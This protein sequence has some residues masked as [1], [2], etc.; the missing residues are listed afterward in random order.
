MSSSTEPCDEGIVS[1]L[2]PPSRYIVSSEWPANVFFGRRMRKLPML[3]FRASPVCATSCRFLEEEFLVNLLMSQ[4]FCLL[5]LL[6]DATTTSDRQSH[7]KPK[8]Y[9]LTHLI[10][11]SHWWKMM[12]GSKSIV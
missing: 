2:K 12:L 5:L 3:G 11:G 1:I 7:A 8:G 4:P 6:G 9:A 10:D